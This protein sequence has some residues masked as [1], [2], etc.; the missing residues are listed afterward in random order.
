MIQESG[1]RQNVANCGI[2]KSGCVNFQNSKL[3]IVP[4]S[5]FLSNFSFGSFYFLCLENTSV[6]K[7]AYSPYT[8][9]SLHV[10]IYKIVSCIEN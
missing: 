10:L 7:I 1:L 9:L 3:F 2:I 8:Y 4:N 6:I 5:F